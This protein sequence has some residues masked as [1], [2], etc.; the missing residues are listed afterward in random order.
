MARVSETVMSEDR[1]LPKTKQ[2]EFIMRKKELAVMEI[3]TWANNDCLNWRWRV[4]HELSENP[5]IRYASAKTPKSIMC[6][7]S[8]GQTIVDD[9]IPDLYE[10]LWEA[11]GKK[12]DKEMGRSFEK[13]LRTDGFKSVMITCN[14]GSTY[15]GHIT[16]VEGC[17]YK[18][19]SLTVE[20][21]VL[22][23]KS[24]NYGIKEVVFANPSTIVKWSDGTK[25]VVTCQDNVQAVEKEIDGKTVTKKK[26]MKADTYSKEVGLAM[27]IA[28]KWA[29]N[30]GNF[31][32]VFRK[33]IDGHTEDSGKNS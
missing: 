25:T 2:A 24:G 32:N 21:E 18:A 4:K 7:L 14:D 13:S 23:E 9:M 27:C 11:K 17:P 6:G 20:A 29:G 3:R 12:E 15:E 5:S 16:R 1:D 19:N 31:N 33:Y 28:K 22:R 8:A 30:K 26:P 10:L